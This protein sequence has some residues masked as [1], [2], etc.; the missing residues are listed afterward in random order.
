MTRLLLLLGLMV[1]SAAVTASGQSGALQWPVAGRPAVVT[2]GGS[3]EVAMTG[4]GA[5]DLVG[6]GSPHT[7]EMVWEEARGGVRRGMATLP[8]GIAPGNYS[9][10][11]GDETR[12]NAVHVVP[13]MEDT[14][15]IAVV[16]RVPPVD[17]GPP[18]PVI[19]DALSAQLTQAAVQLVFVVGPL[20]DTGSP[21][22]LEALQAVIETIPLPVFV[23]PAEVDMKSGA[24]EEYFGQPIHALRY[25]S[26]GYLFLGP[27]LAAQNSAVPQR[28]GPIY[29]YRRA[30]RASRWS[31]GVTGRY[32]LDW[33][34]RAQMA[35]FVDD[36]LDYLLAGEIGTGLTGS[37]P[38]GKA[39]FLPAVEIPA[40]PLL[41][42]DVDVQEIALR[43]VPPGT[44]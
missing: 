33:N 43:Q 24:F 30:I 22:E 40:T 11:I 42:F 26:D 32:G 19:P 21:T 6:T 29:R 1:V 17:G 37:V 36:P 9:L 44:E 3:F 16:R 18:P 2:P 25:A 13:A 39:R 10:S 28:L 34:I 38:W 31:V 15:A 41:I 8:E 14:Y 5:V 12:A 35:L 27:D 4:E 20:T 23:C 7:L